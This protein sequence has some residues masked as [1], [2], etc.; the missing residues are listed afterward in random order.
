MESIIGF[1]GSAAFGGIT[2]LF[3]GIINRIADHYAAK[4]RHVHEREMMDKNTEYLRLESDRD[5]QIA[6][7]K[8]SEVI[9]KSG[10]D[11]MAA[12][13][14]ADKATY[15]SSSMM[16]GLPKW[17]KAVISILMAFVDFVRGLTRPGL[18]L[19]LCI[20][21]TI[22]YME[23]KTILAQLKIMPDPAMALAITRDLVHG[24]I[25]LTTMSVGWWFATRTKQPQV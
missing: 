22:M 1:L 4:E 11:A 2:G 25:Y 14:Q 12:S 15:F 9:E 13:Y 19:Y 17:A 7:E 24:V 16:S 8:A 10:L 18:T 20:L 6:K 3:G 23:Q 5:I 21:T